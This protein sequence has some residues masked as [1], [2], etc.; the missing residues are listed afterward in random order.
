MSQPEAEERCS[1]MPPSTSKSRAIGSILPLSIN[2]YI[3]MSNF[4]LRGY[5][6]RFDI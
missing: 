4:N 1:S 2:I 3:Y 6:D 5:S